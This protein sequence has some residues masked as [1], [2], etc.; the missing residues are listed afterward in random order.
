M[1]DKQ[2]DK[3]DEPKKQ[4]QI[5]AIIRIG[6]CEIGYDTDSVYGCGESKEYRSVLNVDG[7]ISNWQRSAVFEQ[8]S[9]MVINLASEA[10]KEVIKRKR[11]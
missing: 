8:C 7:H 9:F 3:P 2:A 11:T 1:N 5:T 6:N 10:E 4:I